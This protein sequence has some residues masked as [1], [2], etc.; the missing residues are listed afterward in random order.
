MKKGLLVLILIC[1]FFFLSGC[2]EEKVNV[3]I[4]DES[5]LISGDFYLDVDSLDFDGLHFHAFGIRTENKE[6]L[7]QFKEILKQYDFVLLDEWEGIF[8]D[9][10]AILRNLLLANNI[11][12]KYSENQ[13]RSV[14]YLCFYNNRLYLT[15]P[16]SLDQPTYLLAG[17]DYVS[18]EEIEQQEFV[19]KLKKILREVGASNEE[20]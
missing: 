12:K 8:K 2:V 19:S 13:F 14:Y 3:N 6:F 7:I 5:S 10:D 15:I 16:H 9:N 20:N 1:F 17:Y 4:P 11:S 18:K